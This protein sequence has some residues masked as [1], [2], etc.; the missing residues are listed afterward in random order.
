MSDE[1]VAPAESG[2][3]CRLANVRIESDSE[4]RGRPE[5]GP[6]PEGEADGIGGKAEVADRMSASGGGAAAPATWPGSPA[7]AGSS[8]SALSAA[9]IESSVVHR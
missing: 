3:R 5:E 4:L 9:R 2:A 7:V 6:L 1:L 8:H